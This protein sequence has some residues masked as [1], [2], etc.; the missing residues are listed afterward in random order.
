MRIIGMG[1]KN[2]RG[3]SGSGQ[4]VAGTRQSGGW[5][6]V[7]WVKENKTGILLNGS[8]FLEPFQLSPFSFQHRRFS[9]SALTI[10]L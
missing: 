2:D 9:L 1:K 6:S 10:H 3:R 8:V 7:N 4:Q 5:E